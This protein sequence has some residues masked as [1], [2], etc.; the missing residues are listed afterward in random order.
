MR[1]NK[2]VIWREYNMISYKKKRMIKR[3][4]KKILKI[5]VTVLIVIIMGGCILKSFLD[6]KTAASEFPSGWEINDYESFME[7]K[8]DIP[9]DI[10]GMSQYDKYAMGLDYKDGSDSDQD[11]LTDKEEIEKYNTDPL[12]SSTAGDLYTDG[13]KV[14]NG[15]DPLKKVDYKRKIKIND[16]GCS[17]V[18]LRFDEPGDL[19][20]VIKDITKDYDLV[21][22]NIDKLYKGYWING[23]NGSLSIDLSDIIARQ[24]ISMKDIQVYIVEGAFVREGLSEL[25]NCSFEKKGRVISLDYEF[26]GKNNYFIFIS[27]KKKINIGSFTSSTAST[28]KE[29]PAEVNYMLY[30]STIASQIGHKSFTIA[31]TGSNDE[32]SKDAF[33]D[34][35]LKAYKEGTGEDFLFDIKVEAVSEAALKKK[36][37]SLQYLI[38]FMETD[39]AKPQKIY[40]LV[41][42]Y[43]YDENVPSHIGAEK[44]E[45]GDFDVFTDELP[46]QNFSSYIGEHGN[47][48][49]ITHLTAYLYN[50]GK[51][52][53]AGAYICT[54]DEGKKKIKWDLSD[55]PAND[56]LTDPGLYDYKTAAFIDKNSDQNSDH[57]G[58]DISAGEKEFVDMVGC[59]WAEGNDKI[60]LLDYMNTDGSRDNY[61]KVKKMI[62]YLDQGKVLDVYMYFQ[63]GFGHAINIYG[64]HYNSLGEVIFNVY[65]SNLP[66]DQRA[67][68]IL[69]H[70]KC[71]L[72]VKKIKNEN[73]TD[74]FEYL[75]WPIS[76]KNNI[77]YMATSNPALMPKNAMVVMDEDWNIIE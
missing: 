18:K 64:Y 69:N 27:T 60:N 36:Y 25:I 62:K 59:F 39:I 67:G 3:V 12:K 71:Y 34:S 47:C 49:G 2:L 55:D 29:S 68:F 53:S 65:D 50:K 72:G 26:A 66:Q 19:N 21:A 20:T 73:G 43:I 52:P 11:G 76:G 8:K 74:T 13:Y 33:R 75:Y 40:M 77:S 16:G 54:V 63:G 1:G 30:G 14:D 45:V 58:A 4:I 46:F 70:D 24:D 51:L 35:W 17:E 48:A 57:I 38:P 23:Y 6:K 44:E 56:T 41:F 32:S 22:F 37:D 28:S 10:E 42:A 61:S 5:T 9:S 7:I 15:M 31:Y